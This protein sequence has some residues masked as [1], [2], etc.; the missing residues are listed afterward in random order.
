[1]KKL[2]IV[3]MMLMCAIFVSTSTASATLV[4]WYFNP[5]GSGYANATK[6][7]DYLN[8]NGAAY[9]ANSFTNQALGLGTFKEVATF[10]STS[11]DLL[12]DPYNMGTAKELTSVFTGSGSLVGGYFVFSTGLL[13]MYSDKNAADYGSTNGYFGADNGGNLIA[14]FD[15]INGGGTLD[16]TFAPSGQIAA[17]FAAT[18]LQDGYWYD[19]SGNPLLALPSTVYTLGITTTDATMLSSEVIANTSNLTDEYTDLFNAAHSPDTYPGDY[20]PPSYFYLGNAGQLRV[21]IVPEP[22]SMLLLGM[23]ILGLFGL[24]RKKT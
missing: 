18:Y 1:M 6:I 11:H 2:V 9:I 5:D 24:G 13:N 22:G 20:N 19:P 12:T 4:N 8:T 10:K 17:N 23:G 16:S 14:T 21:D 3:C 15:L 7:T